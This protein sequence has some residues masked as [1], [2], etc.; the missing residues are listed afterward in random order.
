MLSGC[1]SGSMYRTTWYLGWG[2]RTCDGRTWLAFN[3]KWR[4][5]DGVLTGRGRL[6][7]SYLLLSPTPLV[8]AVVII[9]A[10]RLCLL[11]I[12]KPG[13]Q[14]SR[15]C[16]FQ[17]SL[18]ITL[19]KLGVF[20]DIHLRILWLGGVFKSPVG[21][22]AKYYVYKSQSEQQHIMCTKR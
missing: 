22:I 6:L 14:F 10:G 17:T 20:V 11:L 3:C 16:N 21:G 15:Q 19:A 13:S 1:H 8:V 9:P 4:L 5:G 12:C 18:P 7:H 2:D